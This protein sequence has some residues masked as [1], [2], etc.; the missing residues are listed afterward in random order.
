VRFRGMS[1]RKFGSWLMAAVMLSAVQ[2]GTVSAFPS[3]GALPPPLTLVIPVA[4]LDGVPIDAAGVAINVTV[5]SP[6]GP[7]FLTVYPCGDTPPT[8][9]VNYSTDQTVPNFVVSALSPDG[10]VCIDTF[11]VADVVVDLAGYVPAGSPIVMLP[12]PARVV[13]SRTGVGLGAPMQA[14]ST[15]AVQVAG[16]S[17]VPADASM[18]LFNAT[19]TKTAAPGYL[20]VF[21]C[22]EPIPPTSTL[23]YAA[24]ATVPN[25]VLARVGAGGQVCLFSLAATDVIVDVAGFLPAATPGVVPLP[26]PA[27]LLDTRTGIGGPVGKL[28]AAGQSVQLAGVADIPANATSVIVNLTATQSSGSGFVSA[29]P[30]GGAAPLVSN[31]NFSPGGDV[32]NLAIVKLGGGELCLTSNNAV[33]VIADVTGYL[34]D[35]ASI[36]AMS[37][38]RIFDS[39]EGVDP[40]CNIGVDFTINGFEVVDLLTGGVIAQLPGNGV[41]FPREF[42]RGDC[43]TID[44]VGFVPALS[45]YR[46]WV[47]DRSGAAISTRTLPDL[48]DKVIFT[49][50]GPL[51]FQRV[52]MDPIP[53]FSQLVDLVSGQILFSVP[54]PDRANDGSFRIML[55]AG[56]TSDGS[57]IALQNPTLDGRQTEVSYW[58]IDGLPLGDWTSPVG[59]FNFRLS[60]AGSYLAYVISSGSVTTNGFVVTLDGSLVATMPTGPVGIQQWITDGAMFGCNSVNGLHAIRWDLFSPVKPLIPGDPRRCP[61]AVR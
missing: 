56:G 32:A 28:T 2:G 54:E 13:D 49:D 36:A 15:A 5:T 61:T 42:V 37:P 4:G 44:V 7:G 19:V 8:S 59:A 55:P 31:L 34:N 40:P 26:A 35:D 6:A 10:D 16:L 33:D 9:N 52:A 23:N 18:V 25:F 12:Q 27:R 38:V 14:S 43:Q 39:R 29:Y 58:T 60:P 1:V 30:C 21:P 46:W 41:Q 11:A 47:F 51:I 22:G 45:Q 48:S 53:P 20:T 50:F 57:L 24:N 17:G 3:G